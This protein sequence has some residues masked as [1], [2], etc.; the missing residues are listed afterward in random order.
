MAV[1]WLSLT[2]QNARKQALIVAAVVLVA[3]TVAI[4]ATI[5]LATKRGRATDNATPAVQPLHPLGLATERERAHSSASVSE[6]RS[7]VEGVELAV[8][9]PFSS[10]GAS[11]PEHLLLFAHGCQHQ[12]SDIL[13]QP[14]GLGL[15]EETK[16]ADLAAQTYNMLVV[17]PSSL[18]RQSG[19]WA[20]VDLAG[21]ARALRSI[22]SDED[23]TSV[24]AFGASSGGSFVTSLALSGE[25]RSVLSGVCAIVAPMST[26]DI[27]SRTAASL[28]PIAF[29]HMP[30]DEH[31]ANAVEHS[32]QVLESAG[33]HAAEGKVYP[34]RVHSGFFASRIPGFA[35]DNS[36]AIVSALQHNGIILQDGTLAYDPR[37][38]D[39]WR[40]ELKHNQ[41]FAAMQDSFALDKSA[42]SEELNVAR[43]YH[44]MVSDLTESVLDFFMSTREQTSRPLAD[45]T[46]Q[47]RSDLG[48]IGDS[49]LIDVA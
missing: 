18:D 34:Q 42:V 39:Q 45:G 30:R 38:D 40:S 27:D 17:A 22:T 12:G 1:R 5:S 26:L 8:K 47:K 13:Q 23:I 43:A 14:N 49:N 11:N 21:I 31:T 19:C 46:K 36:E 7:T 24:F 15:P 35:S 6:Y 9:R 29:V 37:S 4:G 33:V 48:W 20:Q 2:Q 41:E 3:S 25:L 28:P 16:L 32:L 44:E 10:K